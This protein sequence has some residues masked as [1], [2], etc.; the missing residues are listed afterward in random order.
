V[1]SLLKWR[2]VSRTRSALLIF[3]GEDATP[4]AGVAEAA[5]SLMGEP[6]GLGGLPGR[7]PFGQRAQFVAAH[8]GQGW[9]GESR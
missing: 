2:M 8:P 9:G 3:W 4:G 6:F 5:A 1:H 7:E